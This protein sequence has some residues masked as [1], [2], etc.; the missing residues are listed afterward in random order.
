MSQ[1]QLML[2]VILLGMSLIFGPFLIGIARSQDMHRGHGEMRGFHNEHHH[3]RLHH[4][5]EKLMRPDV[6]SMSCC[7]KNDC[8]PTQAK[9]VDGQWR[10]LKAGRWVTVP[11][12]KI[13]QE[14]STDGAA[15][16]CFYPSTINNDDI[17][18]FVRP[19]SGI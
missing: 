13:N 11:N 9:L 6:P 8:T 7:N 18:C 16:I 4:W 2:L 3:D 12:E 1:R 14:E 17:L 19:G 10:A 5:Y 15:H